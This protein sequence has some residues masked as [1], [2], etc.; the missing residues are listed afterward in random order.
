MVLGEILGQLVAGEVAAGDDAVHRAGL[1]EHGQVPVR[2]ALGQRRALEHLGDRQRLARRSAALDDGPPAGRV[3]LARSLQTAG[4][5]LVHIPRHAGQPTAANRPA[6]RRPNAN[7]AKTPTATRTM[8]PPGASPHA[9]AALSPATT[10]AIPMATDHAIT[11]RWRAGEHL[12]PGDG[13]HHQRGHSRIPTT[14]MAATMVTATS[15][16]ST[17]LRART[18]RPATVDHSSSTP[19]RTWPDRQTDRADDHE[20]STATTTTSPRSTVRIEPNR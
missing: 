16:A 4:H 20:A 9:R 18:G 3:A 1:F 11:P 5:E 13:Q 14:R 15:T 7:A 10:D 8:V 2:R 19:W 6:P 17:A 12:A